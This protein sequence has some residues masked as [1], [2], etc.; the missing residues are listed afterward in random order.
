MN[1]EQHTNLNQS[2][3]TDVVLLQVFAQGSVNNI[4]MDEETEIDQVIFSTAK[5]LIDQ[6]TQLFRRDV[7]L[8]SDR[9]SS[10]RILRLLREEPRLK[11]V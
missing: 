2:L 6:R 9:L 7:Q 4:F 8:Q 1:K 11:C 5:K 3:G 10:N